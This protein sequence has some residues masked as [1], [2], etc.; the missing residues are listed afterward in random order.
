[1]HGLLEDCQLTSQSARQVTTTNSILRGFGTR[2]GSK[3]QSTLG[4]TSS[5][6]VM[7]TGNPILAAG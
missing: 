7:V 1:M 6:G 3:V 2:Q 4:G 5:V